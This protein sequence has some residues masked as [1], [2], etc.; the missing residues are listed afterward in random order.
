MKQI[1]KSRK[2]YIELRKR[3]WIFRWLRKKLGIDS[4]A[5]EFYKLKR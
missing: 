1:K 5:L 2:V 4:L 3:H